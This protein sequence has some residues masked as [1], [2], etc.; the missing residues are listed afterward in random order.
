MKRC[1]GCGKVTEDDSLEFCPV[2]GEYYVTRPGGQP[3]PDT[4]SLPDDPFERGC[5]LLDAGRFAEGVQALRESVQ[6]GRA[7]DDAT[8]ARIVDSITGCMLG[9]AL[10][11]DSY[12]NAGMV[13]LAI[14]MPDREPLED[15]MRRL[16]G[17]L[18]VCMIQNGVLGLANSYVYLYLDTFTLYTDLRDLARIS[19]DAARDLGEMLD[20]AMGLKDAF[21]KNGPG[22]LEWLSCYY[23]FAENLRDAAEDAVQSTSAEELDRLAHAWAESNRPIYSTPVANAFA[24]ATHS[25]AG[26]KISSKIL[27][28]SGSSQVRAFAKVYLKGPR[29]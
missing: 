16:A 22:P 10:Q 11:P 13:R 25:T 7:V 21:P 24:M 2:C 28:R 9:I 5:V 20:K 6:A 1:P 15:I 8:Y 26:G 17:S 12:K 29:K 3:V 19:A 18:G 27:S 14:L 4:S 23:N